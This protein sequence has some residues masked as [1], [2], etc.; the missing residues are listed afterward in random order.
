MPHLGRY[1][2]V[3]SQSQSNRPPDGYSHPRYHLPTPL[4][5]SYRNANEADASPCGDYDTPWNHQGPLD[6]L[7]AG[8]SYSEADD[9]D[10]KVD[11]RSAGADGAVDD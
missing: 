8:L 1:A 5:D 3:R 7:A 4:S 11:E 9:C 2:V 10:Q 6:C